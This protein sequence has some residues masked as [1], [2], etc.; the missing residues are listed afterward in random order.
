MYIFPLLL[1]FVAS[2]VFKILEIKDDCFAEVVNLR[3]GKSLTLKHT[4]VAWANDGMLST[5]SFTPMLS[6]F[7]FFFMSRFY[8]NSHFECGDALL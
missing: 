3:L 5:I 8:L 1:I 7:F 2:P 4:D 6:F